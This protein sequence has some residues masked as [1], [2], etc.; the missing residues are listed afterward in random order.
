MQR[1][2]GEGLAEEVVGDVGHLAEDRQ[3][4]R[5]LDLQPVRPRLA[6][7]EDPVRESVRETI[8]VRIVVG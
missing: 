1:T 6:Y 5:A 8:M 3:V 2:C 4:R 7:T